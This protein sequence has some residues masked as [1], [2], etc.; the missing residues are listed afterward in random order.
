MII[1]DGLYS[2]ISLVLSM[3]SLFINNYIAKKDLD[4]FPFGKHILEPIVISIKSLIIGG[5]CIISMSGAVKD[6]F[7]GGNSIEYGAAL[8]YSVVSV[9]GCGSIYFYMKN[10]GTKISSQLIKVEASQWLMD[11]LLSAG[12][13]IGFIIAMGLQNTRFKMLNVYIDPAMVIIVSV[14]FIRMPI[15]TFIN[16]FREVMSVKAADDINEDIYL[17]VKEIEKEYQFEDSI[18]RVSKIGGELRIEVDFIYNDKSK[19]KNLDQM[20]NVREEFN[21]AI[22]HLD[23]T[24]WLNISFTGDRKWAV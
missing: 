15:E 16:S 13:L 11:T 6:I 10:K 4:K 1:F 17:V 5:M 7:A 8:I 19:L 18:A 14:I 3:V 22:S 9:I 24:K 23:Y 2:F 21:K 20:D 12:V